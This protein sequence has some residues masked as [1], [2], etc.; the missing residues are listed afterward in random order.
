MVSDCD[1]NDHDDDDD[2]D[3]DH[4]DGHILP[5]CSLAA[6][7]FVSLTLKLKDK[8]HPPR[9]RRPER[10]KQSQQKR[11]DTHQEDPQC[12]VHTHTAS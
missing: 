6:S 9:I 8:L 12:K 7:Q 11:V 10:A 2:D 3:C 4:S 1:N 5:L